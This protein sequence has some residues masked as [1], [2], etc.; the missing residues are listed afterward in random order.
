M[1]YRVLQRLFPANRQILYIATQERFSSINAAGPL[2]TCRAPVLCTPLPPLSSEFTDN[3]SKMAQKEVT[4]NLI[5]DGR[6]KRLKQVW[7]SLF[8]VW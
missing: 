3:L 7:R 1:K 2:K 4:E 5:R 6:E 8:Y